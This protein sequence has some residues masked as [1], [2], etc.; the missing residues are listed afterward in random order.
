MNGKPDGARPDDPWGGRFQCADGRWVRAEP[1]HVPI[2]PALRRGGGP[3]GLDREGLRARRAAR[4]RSRAAPSCASGSRRSCSRSFRRRHCRRMG[5]ARPPG[6][7]AHHD[8]PDQRR[9]AR[10]RAPERRRASSRRSTDPDAR[11][12]ASARPRRA[13]S[14][15]RR[16]RSGR[17]REMPRRGATRPT[18][19]AFA[20][21]AGSRSAA[22]R[23]APALD[24]IRVV[25][26]TQVLAGPTAT[27]TLAEF[28]ADV[29][30]INNPA[31]GRRGLSLAGSSL[32]H[33][34]Q[35]REA[36]DPARPEAARGPRRLSAARRG[37]RRRP[38]EL[39]AGRRGAPGRRLRAGAAITPDIVYGS[40]GF[41]GEGG[42]WEARAR[43]R[44]ERPGGDGH[45]GA[46]GRQGGAAGHAAVRPERLRDGPARRRSRWASPSSIA[47]STGQGAATSHTSLAA[48]ATTAPVAVSAGLRRQ[49]LGRAERAG[50]ARLGP[51]PA[52]LPRRRDGWLFL[53]AVDAD[54]AR[55][56]AVPGLS[57]IAGLR[58]SD[59]EAALAA[60][61]RRGPRRRVGEPPHR[62]WGR[63]AAGRSP[64]PSSCRIPWV[65]AH[66][67][68]VTR[69]H[70]SGERITTIGPPA[71]LSRTPV[72]PGRPVS[73]P[74]GDAAEILAGIG[75]ANQ[76]DDL[77]AR[78]I[79]A[80][81]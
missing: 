80:L 28:G 49:G 1:R 40:V 32:S 34:R 48:A 66:G 5:G 63:R 4:A 53:G 60:R 51:A 9:V 43:L 10:G 62:R 70:G 37:R 24:G 39:P 55:L 25:D 45:D 29:V 21:R 68:S 31:R 72:I 59:L 14:S 16:A 36:H 33:R 6:E 2:R 67:L 41:C 8:G 71:R 42:P 69:E 64:P 76:L 22:T 58:G 11:P 77:V 12:H 38:A 20:A 19:S 56:D 57:A 65:V 27:R 52:A 81:E 54:L 50:C 46:H 13:A 44:A 47:G 30:K 7:R 35:P 61:A 17:G 26:L 3:I 74:G 18:G 23:A 15:P 79:V 75:L 78:R 73:A